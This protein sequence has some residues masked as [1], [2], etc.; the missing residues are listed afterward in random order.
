MTDDI[1]TLRDRPGLPDNLRVLVEAFPR[2]IWEG[3]Q[4]FGEMVQFW[5]QRHAMFRDLTTRLSDDAQGFLDGAMAAEA[6]AAR[7]ARF[8]GLFFNEL[9]MHHQVEDTH[10]FPQLITLD[11]RIS[12]GFDMLETDHHAIDGLL[13]RFAQTANAVL[14]GP[15][16]GT[17]KD[18]VGAF[19][20]AFAAFAP[21]LERHLTDEE[22]LVVPVILKSGFQG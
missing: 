2:E 21:L 17:A 20:E 11:P 16:D 4:N 15:K 7:L 18:H 3:H 6:Y 9:H 10:Y 13:Q 1:L 22:D 5:L 14:Q 19:L 8:G 12:H